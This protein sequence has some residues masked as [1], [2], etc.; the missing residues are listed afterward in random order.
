MAVSR[1]A[2]YDPRYD[3]LVAA[4]PGTGRAYAPSYWAATAGPVPEDD[5]PVQDD[6][7]TDVAVIGSG[8]TGLATALYLAREHAGAAL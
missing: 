6:I 2:P 7:E 5:G 8:S 1:T 4:D 3:P